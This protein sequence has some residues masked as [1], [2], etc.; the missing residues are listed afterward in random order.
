M[1][2]KVSIKATKH[3]AEEEEEEEA[4]TMPV[5]TTLL[6]NSLYH[7][8]P[9]LLF[10]SS[11]SS[12]LPW[13]RSR[14]APRR[15]RSFGPLSIRSAANAAIHEAA[16]ADAG[17]DPVQRLL[18]FADECI[19]VDENDRVAGHESKYNCHLME[20]IEKE[21]LLHRSFSVFLFNSKYELLLQ[22]RSATKVTF[23]LVWTNTCCS[24]P[25]YRE[26]ELIEENALGV[27]IAAQRKLLDELGLYAEDVPVD[28]FIPLT[29]MLYKA[30][31]DGKWG[32]HELDHLLVIVRDVIVHPNP[33]EVAD[34]KYVN[35][36]QLRELVRK[37]DAGEDGLKLSPWFRLIV[38]NFLFKWWDHVEEGTLKQAADI[39]NIHKLT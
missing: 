7:H 19:L 10:S 3:P 12:K 33:D 17:M 18:M 8:R 36:G 16:D 25:L 2:A 30:P 35:R 4:N 39:E 13:F 37:V 28:Q 22:Q 38:D 31:S 23:P 24:H 34:V 14:L 20:R 9:H 29:R 1:R 27:R 5:T 11:P 15:L 6:N 26:S 21:N 32:E